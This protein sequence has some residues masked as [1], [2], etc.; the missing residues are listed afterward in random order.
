[1]HGLGFRAQLSEISG[2][3]VFLLAFFEFGLYLRACLETDL[4][5][6][7]CGVCRKIM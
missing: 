1:M 2:S 3:V 5:I 6:L 4:R 7:G